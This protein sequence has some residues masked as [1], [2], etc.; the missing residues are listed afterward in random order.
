MEIVFICSVWFVG[1]FLLEGIVIQTK[2][3]K[4]QK[5][6]PSFSEIN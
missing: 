3:E 5:T 6:V 1:F 2:D 4:E